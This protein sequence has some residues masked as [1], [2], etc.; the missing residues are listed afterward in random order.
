[1]LTAL[2]IIIGVAA[3]IIMVSLGQ[4]ASAQVQ[5]RLQG[6]GTNVLTIMPGS[7]QSGGCRLRTSTISRRPS[8]ARWTTPPADVARAERSA[9]TPAAT[10]DARAEARATGGRGAG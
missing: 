7:A 4:G 2:G 3:V 6:L 10:R 1:M 9:G 5:E 8:S